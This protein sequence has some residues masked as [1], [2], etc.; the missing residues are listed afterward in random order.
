[1]KKL[2]AFFCLFLIIPLVSA[3]DKQPGNEGFFYSTSDGTTPTDR[4]STPPE[5]KTDA[6]IQQL[7]N[8]LKDARSQG[9]TSQIQI[10]ENQINQLTG[11]RTETYSGQSQEMMTI[12]WTK[13]DFNQSI[14]LPWNDWGGA[15]GTVES[16]PLAG[17]IFL[18]STQ[19]N[20]S[21]GDTMT[22]LQSTNGGVTWTRLWSTYFVSNT[23]YNPG[24]VDLQIAYSGTE[25]WVYVVAGY[26][27]YTTS[28]RRCWMWRYNATTNISS[29]T[30][31]VFAPNSATND[32]YCPRVCTDAPIWNSSAYVYVIASCDSLHATT[33]H[34]LKQKYCLLT[35]PFGTLTVTYRNPNTT[36]SGWFYNSTTNP[37]GKYLSSDIGYFNAPNPDRLM[38]SFQVNYGSPANPP[39]YNVVLAWSDDFGV[40]NTGNLQISEANTSS[41]ARIAFTSGTSQYGMIVY[42]RSFNAT[43]WDPYF[44]FTSNGGTNWS[45]GGYV[46]ASGD[47]ERGQVS[48]YAPL[49]TNNF[50]VGY[51][52]EVSGTAY[53]Y[54][55]K[56]NPGT[57][58]FPTAD[59]YN[60]SGSTRCD[61]VY[62]TNQP[63][64]RT[65]GGDD[66]LSIWRGYTTAYTYCSYLCS[67]TVG[68]Q[69]NNNEIPS[70]YKLEQNYPNPFNPSTNIKF[71]LPN[72]GVVKLVV[73]DATGREVASLLNDNLNAGVY[74]VNF[75]A[76][77]LSSGVY[78][79]SITSG[80]FTETKKM[81]LV[82]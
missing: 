9:N 55:A 6:K 18:A 23:D 37:A 50:R 56:F 8:Q 78:F 62:G 26:Y 19:W 77:S 30:S 81:L 51:S 17:R 45:T 3:Q 42:Q 75:D 57:N 40:S 22:L 49:T 64:A 2:F 20:G 1:M 47:R 74:T 31:L 53:S 16:G 36:N 52:Q 4:L 12:D 21:G 58:T 73:Y 54:N 48:V 68:I 69:G 82:K 7:T 41:G 80:N 35:T 27:D 39:A 5:T 15:L 46:D 43:D 61:T 25:T 14:A 76:S 10:I 11:S 65:G 71:S 72:S 33:Q 28:N 63:G 29:N 32:Y 34:W 44:R 38:T 24:E 59:I 79:Y 70:S 66:C 13:M 60:V 67:G